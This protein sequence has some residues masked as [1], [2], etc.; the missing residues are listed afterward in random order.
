VRVFAVAASPDGLTPREVAEALG[1]HQQTTYHL[2]H[3]LTTTGL[4]ARRNDRYI[5]GIRCAGLADAFRRQIAPPEFLGPA[6]REI[7]SRTGET[8]Q[9]VGWQNDEIVAFSIARGHHTVQAAEVPYGSTNDGHARATGK[10]L[11]AHASPQLRTA[12]LER[13]PLRRRT[14]HTITDPKRFSEELEHIRERGYAVDD[15]EF[16]DGVACLAVPLGD[17][18]DGLS[19][20][21][22]GL[23]A[24]AGR[25]R[26]HLDEYLETMQDV[27]RSVFASEVGR[28]E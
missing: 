3:T 14:A 25:L 24:P 6:V 26:A 7:A 20:F 15:E 12:Y 8:A 13:F 4:L 2:L 10:L 28:A 11:L 19:Q 16:A 5:L 23:S 17:G 27:A 18:I 1:I 21:G 22:F 9:G